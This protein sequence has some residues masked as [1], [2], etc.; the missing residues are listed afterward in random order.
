M[1]VITNDFL[2]EGNLSRFMQNL[3]TAYTVYYNRRHQRHGHVLD[4]RFKAKVVS[5]DEYSL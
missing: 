1:S 2:P 5:E 4:G 3:T